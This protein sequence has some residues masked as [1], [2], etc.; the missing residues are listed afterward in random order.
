MQKNKKETGEKIIEW[1]QKQEIR[2]TLNDFLINDAAFVRRLCR[3][4]R[5]RL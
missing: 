1:K 2:Q 4:S 3:S 5:L